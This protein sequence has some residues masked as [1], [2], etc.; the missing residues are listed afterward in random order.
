L[1]Q[2]IEAILA[3]LASADHRAGTFMIDVLQALVK[4][5][6][7]G[8]ITTLETGCGK[9]TIVFSNIAAKHVCF[10]Y[11][12][13][14][15]SDSS[16]LLVQESP[17]FKAD[18]TEWVFGP[19][20]K[21]IPAFKFEEGRTFDVILIDGPHGYPFPD[22]EYAFLY[23]LLK[24]GSILIVDDIHI[25]NIGHMYDLLR[26]DRMY[27]EIGVFAST[28]VLRRTGVE[29]VPPDGDH[30][31]EQHYNVVNFPRPMTKY[32]VDRSVALDTVVDFADPVMVAKHARRGIEHA[33]V[34]DAGLPS[35][36][37]ARTV[38]I[39]AVFGFKLP[40]GSGDAVTISVTYRSLRPGVEDGAM[41]NVGATSHPL[42]RHDQMATE[43]FVF[44]VE[45]GKEI[46]LTL[47]HPNAVAEHERGLAR[48]EFRRH[49]ALVQ[50]I[51]LSAAKAGTTGAASSGGVVQAAVR[52]LKK[53][54]S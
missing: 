34:S 45:P 22:L 41:I 33:T 2:D 37:G 39:G 35:V 36:T 20:Q 27:D 18:R 24:E 44:P 23:P 12:D 19:T 32:A 7:K 9:S 28:G 52:S 21:T 48:Y 1:A 40:E 26:A 53:L 15:L 16:V 51:A 47:L 25:P 50:S 46:V 11:D 29:G 31:W 3:N 10:A 17:D 43:S 8:P 6:P 49:S 13:R 54:W 4:V 42:P 14:K 30:W 5:L 38:D